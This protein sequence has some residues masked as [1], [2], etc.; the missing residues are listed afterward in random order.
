MIIAIDG[1]AGSG[2]ST[3]AR[4]IAQKLGFNY[5]ETGSMYRAVAW[6][7]NKD[8]I[9]PKD[10]DKVSSLAEE[11]IIEFLPSI[12][13][14]RV[15]VNGKDLTSILKTESIGQIAAIVAANPR[16]RELM[17][18]KQRK[19]GEIDNVVMD[20]RD[21]G[22]DVFP[23]AEI[24]FFLNADPEERAHRRYLELKKKFPDLKLEE[25]IKQMKQ[26]DYEDENRSV[27]PLRPAEDAI[28]VDTTGQK[29]DEVIEEVFKTIQSV[30]KR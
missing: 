29:I 24:K 10:L 11:L 6:K 26:R 30:Q 5:I 18:A 25:V 2:K 15:L 13:G 17:V 19:M 3:V 14:Q 23:N 4:I 1:P 9:D 7:T 8:N 16:V 27:S 20:G 22:T 21:I 28:M 12:E